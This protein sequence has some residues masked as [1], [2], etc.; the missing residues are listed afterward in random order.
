VRKSCDLSGC[1]EKDAGMASFLS[2]PGRV[3]MTQHFS[4]TVF[5]RSMTAPTSSEPRSWIFV[6][7]ITDRPLG[8]VFLMRGSF[9][10]ASRFRMTDHRGKGKMAAAVCKFP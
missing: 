5:I 8:F 6:G 4:Q 2:A 10:T 7:A 1:Y 3:S 9:F